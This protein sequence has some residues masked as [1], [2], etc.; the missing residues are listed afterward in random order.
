MSRGVCLTDTQVERLAGGDAD[1]AAYAE[2]L[3]TC[4]ACRTRLAAAEDDAGF[5][6][7]VGT[8]AGRD[9][10]PVGAPRLPGY[11]ILA[12][13]STGAQGVVFKAVQ[14]ST[15]RTVAIKVISTRDSGSA[16][17]RARAE[18]EAE[19]VA[20]LHHPNIV[21]VYESRT[22]ADERI[23]V[24]MEF[25]DGMPFDRWTP[26]G[27]SR[28]DQRRTLLTTFISVCVA[29][30]HAHLN[31]VIH[32]DLKPDNIL[33]DPR[34]RPVVV[35]FGIAKAGGGLNTTLI[36][37]FAGTPA[38]AS[39]EQAQGRPDLVDAL[40][41]VYSLGVILYRLL[42]GQLPYDLQGSLLEI[43]RTIG[44]ARPVPLRDR[45]PDVDPDLAAIVARAME[46]RR[47]FRYQSA[48]ALAQDLT[49]HLAGEPVDARGGSGWYLL[50]K[51]VIVNRRRLALAAS[52][53][54]LILSAGA[55]VAWSLASAADAEHTAMLQRSQARADRIRS[56]AV[57]EVFG[58]ALPAADSNH[59]DLSRELAAGLDRLYLRLET[60]DFADEPEFDQSLRRLWGEVY[61]GL[62]SGKSESMVQYA[63]VS[64]R[65]GLLRLKKDLGPEHPEIAETLHQLA[66]VLLVRKRFGEAEQACRD[67]LSMQERLARGS[68]EGLS[69]SHAL[70][71]RILM[72]Q[73]RTEEAV[74]EADVVIAS[75][76][77]EQGRTAALTLASMT[78]LKGRTLLDA[79][80]PADAEPLV[81]SALR[82]RLAS[83]ATHDPD[84]L[85]SLADASSVAS[86]RR[87]GPLWDALSPVWHDPAAELASDLPLLAIP[88][89]TGPDRRITPGATA[90]RTEALRRLV[91]LYDALFGKDDPSHVRA[92]MSLMRAAQAEGRYDDRAAAALRAAD[93]LSLR[94]G[95]QDSSVVFC[96][97]EAGLALGFS[98]HEARAVEVAQR[99]LAIRRAAPIRDP[100][101]DASS[102][103]FLAWF[104]TLAGDYEAGAAS[105]Q[106]G[107]LTLEALLGPDHHAV[108]LTRSGLA[109]CQLELSR[110]QSG[111]AA[112][113]LRA[114]ADELSK[115]A[116][117]VARRSAAISPDQ[118]SQVLLARG[119]VLVQQ[120]RFAEARETML[121]A[122]GLFLCG[123]EPVFPWRRAFIDDMA[124]ACRGL[125]DTAAA[126]AWET[127]RTAPAGLAC[128]G[129]S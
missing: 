39:P 65:H 1:H 85:A 68:A 57:S 70:L 59:P 91:L 48:A 74:R 60:G 66:G 84:L 40:T 10:A 29:V 52:L 129:P 93:I 79:D 103:R 117:E 17:Q 95:P 3:A 113:V 62:G 80:R 127:Q 119:R 118:M 6:K 61:T 5:L 8:L 96:L 32:R 72:A 86:R 120:G 97:D 38:Y 81:L 30:H 126:E 122:W 31:G 102:L 111:P 34:G 58:E 20:R 123:C 128:E 108:A 37:E 16:R 11:R 71:A 94:F 82:T 63:E 12:E 73:G 24:V 114:E 18:R 45:V 116:L 14:E 51:A 69:R 47:E 78:A 13:L 98:G 33:V 15:Q 107:A 49:R 88:S 125:G 101:L 7:R 23:A 9:L 44:E 22:L 112:E 27:L 110:G 76:S 87:T 67:S 43:A 77:G 25:I 28:A 121:P 36:G 75:L 124:A 83:L 46:K 21:A 55:A 2:H 26:A 100:L 115:R 105:W 56:R 99:A 19:I 42:S 64:L 106:E 109:L 90:P 53:S 92:L 50:R 54:L 41:D 4:E 35:D 89:R 104:Q